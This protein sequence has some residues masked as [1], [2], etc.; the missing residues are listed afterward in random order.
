MST[1]SKLGIGLAIG[2]GVIMLC[3]CGILTVAFLYGA[4]SA[5]RQSGPIFPPVSTAI[6]L[7]ATPRPFNTS[8]VSG[9]PTPFATADPDAGL[10]TLAALDAIEVPARDLRE[11][12]LR[13]RGIDSIPE[14]VAEAPADWPIGQELTFNASDTDT[15]ENFTVDATLIYKTENVYF[16]AESGLEVDQGDVQALVDDFQQ[17]AYPTNREFFGSEWNP[18]VD[19]DPRLYILYARGLGFSVAGYYSSNDQYSKLA[20]PDSNEKEMFYINADAVDPGDSFIRSVLAHEFQHMIHW[21]HDI[22][23]TTWLNEGSS[24]LAEQ[25]N[26]FDDGGMGASFLNDPDLQLTTWGEGDNYPHYGAAYLFMSYFLDRFGEAATQQLVADLENGMKS[27]DT[28]L[29]SLG[30]TGP[31]GQP[32]T[33]VDVFADWVVA[34]YLNDPSVEGGRFGYVS[35]TGI[36]AAS[37]NDRIDDCAGHSERTSVAQ[38]GADYFQ[39]DCPGSYALTFEGAS[40]AQVLPVELI[41]GGHAIWANRVDESVTLMTA[42]FDLSAVSAATLTYDAWWSIEA[43]YDYAY[44]EISAD[45]GNTWEL[46]RTPNMTDSD[47][48]GQNFGWAYTDESGGWKNEQIDLSAYSGKKVFVRFEYITDAAVNRPG[49]LI[50]NVAIPEIGYSEDFEAGVGAW[51]LIGMARIDNILPQRY[52]VQ[53]V[54]QSDAGVIVERLPIVDGLG[55]F[56]LQIGAD[57][58]VTLVVSGLTPYTTEPAGY[59]FE[60]R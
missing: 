16:F 8:A 50:D 17:N 14:V 53:I 24:V 23:E 18:G 12:A 35:N 32:L 59:R 52:L 7:P 31:D 30:Q 6:A 11:V 56:D 4:V 49:F 20:Y 21:Y 43:D 27:V 54:R 55:G 58:T 2:L 33:H 26:D 10:D 44:V 34:N 47:P 3:C 42:E 57:E 39:L 5:G 13:L 25:L 38:F 19:G 15:N 60:L 48:S 29:A 1:N 41:D 45:G 28:V 9:T 36:R 40:T 51:E 22:N 37:P 46:L